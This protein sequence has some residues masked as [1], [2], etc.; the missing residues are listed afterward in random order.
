MKDILERIIS[1]GSKLSSSHP[2]KKVYTHS[3]LEFEKID[4][5]I[6]RNATLCEGA[7]FLP[8]AYTSALNMYLERLK[9][10]RAYYFEVSEVSELPLCLRPPVVET[11]EVVKI[12][13]EVKAAYGDIEKKVIIHLTFTECKAKHIEV[14]G[15]TVIVFSENP[16]PVSL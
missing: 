1:E 12:K 14:Q 6:H 9:R 5:L 7:F 2:I 3:L 16:S 10:I 11:G 8:G 4:N 15:R 13:R